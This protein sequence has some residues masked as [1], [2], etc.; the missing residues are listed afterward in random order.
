MVKY[1][2]KIEKIRSVPGFSSAVLPMCQRKSSVVLLWKSGKSSA[3]LP[4]RQSAPGHTLVY[5]SF[6]LHAKTPTVYPFAL[7]ATYVYSSLLTWDD[8]AWTYTVIIWGNPQFNSYE[9]QNFNL[10][11]EIKWR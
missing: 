6:P 7:V 3:F 4:V 8:C 9:E 2:L 5:Y 1:D 10:Q 11:F